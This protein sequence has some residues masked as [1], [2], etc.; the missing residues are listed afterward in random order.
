MSL[1]Q[2][3]GSTAKISCGDAWL[4]VALHQGGESVEKNFRPI[5]GIYVQFRLIIC[6]LIIGV[7]ND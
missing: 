5:Q 2:A 6:G 1:S 3:H 4:V 7:H